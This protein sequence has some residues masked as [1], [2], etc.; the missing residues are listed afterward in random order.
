MIFLNKKY[1]RAYFEVSPRAGAY[2]W[3][4]SE[5]AQAPSEMKN[6]IVK[7]CYF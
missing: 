4:G 1:I 2:L 5:G 3:G 7:D 6:T